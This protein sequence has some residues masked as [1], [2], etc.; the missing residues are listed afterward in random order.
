MSFVT[1][2]ARAISITALGA[3][4]LLG[5]IERRSAFLLPPPG[6]VAA[7]V[8]GS[9]TTRVTWTP[10]SGV[11]GHEV[12]R[13]RADNLQTIERSSGQLSSGAAQWDDSGLLAGVTYQY[14]VTAMYSS[15]TAKATASVTMPAAVIATSPTGALSLKTGSTLTY[16]TTT[17]TASVSLATAPA[18]AAPTGV[19]ASLIRGGVAVRW[20]GVAE[21]TSYRILRAPD[22]TTPPGMLGVVPN[23]S[24]LYVDSSLPP[25]TPAWYQVVTIAADGRTAASAPVAFTPPPAPP[26]LSALSPLRPYP[27]QTVTL[28]G[29]YLTGV[30]AIKVSSAP[31][32]ATGGLTI[33]GQVAANTITAT[34]PNQISF[35]WPLNGSWWDGISVTLEVTNA[36][37][38]VESP[39]TVTVDRRP[40]ITGATKPV[41]RAGYNIELTGRNLDA[42]TAGFIGD[43]PINSA[44]NPPLTAQGGWLGLSAII[45]TPANCSRKGTLQLQG[46]Y[47]MPG[48]TSW[49]TTT[50]SSATPVQG[51]CAVTP[52]GNYVSPQVA[53]PGST[54]RVAGKGFSWI[55]GI[56]YG[57]TSL[58]WTPIS[59]IEFDL[60]IPVP[61]NPDTWAGG[62]ISPQ[63]L[64]SIPDGTVPGSLNPAPISAYP[65]L[66]QGLSAVWAECC[67]SVV[68]TGKWL[69]N[70]VGGMPIVKVNGVRVQVASASFNAVTFQ[71]PYPAA[72]DLGGPAP[73]SIEHPGGSSTTP[74]PLIL[75]TDPSAI[76]SISPASI[77]AGVATTVTVTGTNLARARGICLPGANQLGP[78]V[79]R[80]DP[81]TSN[82]QM[83]VLVNSPA[84]S[85]PISVAVP[86]NI[87][88]RQ[89]T[90]CQANATPVNI[91]VH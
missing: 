27:G 84:V 1:T 37:G 22:A 14:V 69:T 88:Q 24:G 12:T 83:Q 53:K 57:P 47:P 67:E 52:T 21:A 7:T 48:L 61:P 79:L 6:A 19:T 43:G 68:L 81:V 11:L 50:I 5:Q 13:Y 77:S 75:V 20:Q 8:T 9:S 70:P 62:P 80:T 78:F 38:T 56:Q 71:V 65:P 45:R 58:K 31:V 89:Y 72:G 66:A 26:V 36:G 73:V 16:Q 2:M 29:A 86:P 90:I 33:A 18:L 39:F 10:P 30:T 91:V 82:T 40:V 25:Y 49:S 54:V 42:A 4:S 59:D 85:G 76:T 15:G 41:A 35:Q 87:Q 51:G 32:A 60:E 63:L 23:T 28:T 74:T 44:A 17:T 3:S 34:S 64:N 46:S 55:T